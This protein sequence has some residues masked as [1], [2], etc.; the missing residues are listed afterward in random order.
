VPVQGSRSWLTA[1]NSEGGRCVR[2]EV[3]AVQ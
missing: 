1:C 2:F 3:L